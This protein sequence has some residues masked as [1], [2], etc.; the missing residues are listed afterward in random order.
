[1]PTVRI[2]ID[3][4]WTGASGSPGANV[5]HGR[6]G[7]ELGGSIDLGLLT[8]ILETF[9][10][11]VALAMPQGLDISYAGFAYGV[12]DDTGSEYTSDAWEVSGNV[13]SFAPP[14]LAVQCTW[15]TQSGGRNGRGRTF[16]GPMGGSVVQAD[17]SLDNATRETI[18]G[19]CDDLV[20]SSDSFAN[21]ALGVYS[22]VE[23]IFRDVTSSVV[24]DRFAMLRTRR[25]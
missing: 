22:R 21:G 2:P 1:M 16:L 7:A 15:K 19:L 10:T 13:P 6:I 18:Q 25:D 20:E 14:G 9:Y 24:S 3:L 12:G 4:Q 11:G 23:N 5:F 17:G 8:G